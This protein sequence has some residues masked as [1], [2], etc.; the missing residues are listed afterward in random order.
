MLTYVT[1]IYKLY[2]K[3]GYAHLSADTVKRHALRIGRC[4]DIERQG[5]PESRTHST[6][7]HGAAFYADAC[8]AGGDERQVVVAVCEVEG[9]GAELLHVARLVQDLHAAVKHIDVG[10]LRAAL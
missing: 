3:Y 4:T 9:E 7:R 6:H 2:T 10:E 1:N 5:L 8:G